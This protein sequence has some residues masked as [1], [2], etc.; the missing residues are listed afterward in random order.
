MITVLITSIGC[1]P[2]S[3]ISRTLMREKKY[4][5]I[6][7][8]TQQEC[9][10]NFITDVF[11]QC[12]KTL[13]SKYEVFVRMIIE[14]YGID[15]VFVTTPSD[16]GVW[17]VLKNTIDCKVFINDISIINI[18]DDKLKTYEWCIEN[19]ITVPEI[20][21]VTYRPCVIKPK[22]GCGSQG[23][24]FLRNSD[25]SPPQVNS[26]CIVQRLII[27]DEYTVDVISDEESNIINIVWHHK[28]NYC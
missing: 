9:I 23:I 20:V 1:A 8:D 10:G 17:S 26:D 18:A 2:A 14:K 22:K 25:E 19:N 4:R 11:L 5:I 13:D 6:G 21:D 3:A 24:T 28:G 15:A 7:I 12:P 16:T 27:G